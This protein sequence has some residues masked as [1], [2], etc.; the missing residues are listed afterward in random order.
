[1]SR[2][3][4]VLLLV[5]EESRTGL[6][7]FMIETRVY[8][9]VICARTP[10]LAM[11]VIEAQLPDSVAIDANEGFAQANELVREI[12]ARPWGE[13]DT[14]VP[15]MIFGAIKCEG[16]SRADLLLSAASTQ[17]ELMEA[18]R[19]LASRKRG[20]RK[21]VCSESHDRVNTENLRLQSNPGADMV[22]A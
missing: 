21:K 14:I 16:L 11:M 6:L 18:I 7:K 9:R 3:K 4:K 8:F 17:A 1:M 2:P 10:E 19:I 22:S 12:K 5:G 20:P 15:V 13:L